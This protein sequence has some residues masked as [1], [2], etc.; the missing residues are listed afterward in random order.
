MADEMVGSFN[1]YRFIFIGN[2][3]RVG[4]GFIGRWRVKGKNHYRNYRN[5]YLQ[6]THIFLSE[7]Y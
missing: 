7:I 2:L 1:F 5:R 4:A 6:R 3:F